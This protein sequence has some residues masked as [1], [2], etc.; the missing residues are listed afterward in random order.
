MKYPLIA[1]LVLVNPAV[2]AQQKATF[3]LATYAAPIGWK[4]IKRTNDVVGYA[5]TDNQKG[6]YCQLAIFASTVSKGN[7]KTDFE[8]EWQELVVKPY[9]PTKLPELV[10]SKAEDGWE[11]QGGVATFEFSGAQSIAM[12]VTMSGYARCMSIVV[13]TNTDAYQKEIEQFLGSVDLRKPETVS[14]PATNSSTNTSTVKPAPVPNTSMKSSFA[15]TTTNFDDGWTSTV[16]EDWVLVS[17]ENIKVLLHYPNKQADEYNSDVLDGLKNAWNILVA[18]RYKSGSNFDFKYISGWQ[19]LQFGEADLVENATGKQVHV[20]LCKKNYSGGS[21]RYMEIITADKKSFE[22][23]FGVFDANSTSWDKLENMIT[24]N[25]FA[26]AATDLK[27]KWTSNFTG[28]QQYVNAYTGAN[29]GMSTHASNENFQFT[30]TN[31][32][33][34]NVGVASGFVGNIKFQSAK[35]AGTFSVPTPWQVSF[36]DIEGKPQTYNA[37]FTCIKGARILWLGET[38]FGKVE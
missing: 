19:V 31:T 10:P 27:G 34:W 16:H 15:F 12:L 4:E 22:Q 6:T 7:L 35:S 2:Y 3:D 26:V 23:Y 14:R 29:A 21:G 20:V 17:R 37:Q 28:T 5:I 30:G 33:T 25:K 32:Y 1:F 9:K 8:S 13:L 38:A 18:P 11:A 36:S 24:Y